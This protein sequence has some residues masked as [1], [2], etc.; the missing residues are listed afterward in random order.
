MRLGLQFRLG[1]SIGAEVGGPIP[2][3]PAGGSGAT[4]GAT[5]LLGGGCVHDLV[6]GPAGALVP[7]TALWLVEV[8][9]E[10][11]LVFPER[12]AATWAVFER[13]IS[14]E[15]A[16]AFRAELVFTSPRDQPP[17]VGNPDQT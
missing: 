10:V 8:R 16:A 1:R 11:A 14:G 9:V 7:R 2:L 5:T 3:G 17:V 15:S 12:L 6:V 13:L 4:T